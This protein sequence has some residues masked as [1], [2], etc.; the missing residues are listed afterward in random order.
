MTT[1]QRRWEITQD[2]PHDLHIASDARL[3]KTS[4]VNDQSWDIRLGSGEEPS[5][6]I[7]TQYGQRVGLA[8]LVPMWTINKRSIY[9]A[10]TYHNQ[11]M[12]TGFAPNRITVE[13]DIL[14]D[15][16]LV[17][18]HIAMSSQV[19]AGIYTLENKT[20]NELSIRLDLFGHVIKNDEEQKLAIITM[21]K[22]EG[23]ALSLGNY[24]RLS[25]VVLIEDGNSDTI[26][27]GNAR[28]KIGKSITI[29]ANSTQSI[30]FV[31]VGLGDLRQSLIEARRWLVA[32]W[33]G[34]IQSIEQASQAIPTIQTGNLDWDLVI[35]SAYNRLMQSIL[36]ANGNFPRETFVTGRLPN[37]GFSKSGNGTDYPRMWQ[38]QSVDSAYLLTQALANIN[39]SAV[40]GIIR[41]YIALQ[42]KDGFIDLIPNLAG[43]NSDIL[44]T[45]ILARMAW[46]VYEASQDIDFLKENFDGL[47]QFF[48]HCLNQDAD[49]DG[50]P[51]WLDQ[52][53]THYSAFPTFGMGRDWAQGA[54]IKFIES[55]DLIAY[56]ISEATA[57]SKMADLLQEKSAKKAIDKI[58]KTL[59]TALDSMWDTDHYAYRDRD[60]HIS[61]SGKDLLNEGNGD[62]EHV[63]E[64]ALLVPSRLVIKIMGGA[65]HTPKVTLHIAGINTEGEPIKE[66][67][68]VG[69]FYWYTGEG[70]Y[71]SK[72]VFTQVN[73]IWCEGLSR[74]YRINAKTLDTTGIDINTLMPLITDISK[75]KADTLADLALNSEAF[76]RPNGIT[77]THLDNHFDPA[78]AEGAGGIWMYW[79]TLIAEGLIRAGKGSKV[80]DIV[81]SQLDMLVTILSENHETAQFYH[82]DEARG[83]SEKGHVNGSA[84]VYLIQKL[85]GIQVL[86]HDKVVLSENFAWGRAV[87]IRQHGV[88]VRRTTKRIKIEFSSGE[89]VELDTPLKKDEI[90][91]A[92]KPVEKMSFQAIELTS[93]EKQAIPD[94]VPPSS[95]QDSSSNRVIIEVDTE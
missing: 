67:A 21:S 34:F 78:N 64:T 57:L 12:I 36:K 45:P 81:K 40:Q 35:A 47:L 92:S 95:T 26:Y 68:N 73:K 7:Q 93:N 79:Q 59:S 55:P 56:L 88:Y 23:H 37:Y 80:T 63:L 74:V 85:M 54:N 16:H 25:P 91:H 94:P 75:A 60:T 29:P 11:A 70:V 77:M 65:R 86:S 1:Q 14:P 5:I 3:S 38:G 43:E 46:T 4:Y 32:D 62:I 87:T 13:A 10:Q 76:L 83:R 53:Q 52:R 72:T 33:Q 66:T 27:S 58:S 20:K 30:R 24:A 84:P 17:A 39:P 90:I 82:S 2:S 18:D 51:E 71:T 31:H 69:A 15:L 44:C 9:Q 22:G 48:E 50:I 41:N 42:K 19:I 6:K 49:D 89:V 8:S 28:P 61:S